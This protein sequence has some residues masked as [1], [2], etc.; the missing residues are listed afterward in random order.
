MTLKILFIGDP[1]IQIK[2]LPEIDLLLER[3]V[4]LIET[5][6][7]DFVLIAG[8]ILHN[9]ER[10][11]TMALNKAC[12]FIDRLRQLSPVW[13]LVGNHDM[14]NADQFL[15]ENHWM[16]PLKEWNN[17]TIADKVIHK[18][19][20]SDTFVLVPFVPP[21]RFIEALE[22]SD[23]DW[24]TATCI[25]AH[26]EFA[27]CKMG[28]FLSDLGDQWD[29]TYPP[30]VS[31]HIHSCQTPQANIYYSGS[32]LQHAF[33]ESERNVIPCLTFN[34]G[35][36]TKEE[37]DLELPRKHIVYLDLDEIDSYA[38]VLN[39]HDHVK[40]SLKGTLEEFKAFQKTQKYKTLVNQGYKV[41]FR[42]SY[43]EREDS[44]LNSEATTQSFTSVLKELVNQEGN[45]HLTAAYEALV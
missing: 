31:G 35:K 5:F 39:D 26:Q 11:H 16:N 15:T 38:G 24:K 30:V 34:D 17:V 40:L 27:G 41:S 19:I 37:V 22:T 23:E 32:A 28:A 13:I 3:L 8:D 12:E 14:C 29:L 20:G 43:T 44:R 25:F 36:M 2:N 1:H 10:L 45:K 21:G 33:G 7:P 6:D 9:H 4:A 18:T 42:P